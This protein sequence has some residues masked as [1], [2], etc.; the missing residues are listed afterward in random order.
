[1]SDETK[2]SPIDRFVA[3]HKAY[4]EARKAVTRTGV[5]A[6]SDGGISVTVLTRPRTREEAK[7]LA[8]NILNILGE[9]ID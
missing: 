4:D 5:T 8:W 2:I 3:A 6:T 9:D 7:H 1:M